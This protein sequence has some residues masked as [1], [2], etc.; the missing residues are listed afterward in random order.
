VILCL[1]GSVE[2][3][4]QAF[5]SR[6]GIT[7]SSAVSFNSLSDIQSAIGITSR[8]NRRD[9]RVRTRH[10]SLIIMR[11]RTFQSLNSRPGTNRAGIRGT[12]MAYG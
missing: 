10:A 2:M 8:A 9:R 1:H 12:C 6:T 11:L 7:T 4:E 5:G 3:P